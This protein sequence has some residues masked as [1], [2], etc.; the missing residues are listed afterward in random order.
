M[1]SLT[2]A[3]YQTQLLQ[4]TANTESYLKKQGICAHGYLQHNICKDCGKSFKTWQEAI[5]ERMEILDEYF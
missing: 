1:T 4:H 5:D 2:D 3:D